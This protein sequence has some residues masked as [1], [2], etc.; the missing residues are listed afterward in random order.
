[1]LVAGILSCT[2]NLSTNP[3]LRST[4]LTA[5]RNAFAAKDFRQALEHYRNAVNENPGNANAHAWRGYMAALF[6]EREEALLGY[7]SAAALAPS[8]ASYFRLGT[9]AGQLGETKIAVDALQKALS[10]AS[11]ESGH[12]GTTKGTSPLRIAEGLLR[13]LFEAPDRHKALSFARSQGWISEGIDFCKPDTNRSISYGTAALL[14]VLVH[15]HRAECA[16]GLSEDLTG[17]G[18]YRLPSM[19]LG[20]LVKTGENQQTK[21]KAEA[22]IRHRLPPHIIDKRTEWL[23]G[24][25]ITLDLHL[26]LPDEAI[27]FFAKAIAADPRFAQPYYRIGYI[28]WEKHKHDEAISWLRKALS[29]QPDHWRATYILGCVFSSL[30][31]HDEA[32]AQYQKAVEMNPEDADGFYLIG[33]T[34]AKQEKFEEALPSFEKAVALDPADAYNRWY[35]SWVLLKLGRERE[36]ERQW[37]VALRLNPR[38]A[39]KSRSKPTIDQKLDTPK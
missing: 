14:A 29:V 24:T 27:A 26:K 4:S 30:D 11:E 8:A 2:A 5:G 20:E 34:L 21:Q 1:M 25:G 3:Q 36:S 13:I 12:T 28:L 39:E 35:L 38:L 10:L 23:N 33:S 16:L 7:E 15:P 17:N 19:I 32:L 9:F 22:F 37:A 31:R 18:E 6:G